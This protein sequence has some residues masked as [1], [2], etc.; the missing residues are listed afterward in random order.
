M[1]FVFLLAM[2]VHRVQNNLRI[3]HWFAIAVPDHQ[4]L[5]GGG[6]RF[7]S[8][9]ARQHSQNKE[10]G[11]FLQVIHTLYSTEFRRTGVPSP[12]TCPVCPGLPWISLRFQLLLVL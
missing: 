9:H 5:Q 3:A 4:K 2:F 7:L 12:V 10:S 6:C 11:N 8:S 1:A